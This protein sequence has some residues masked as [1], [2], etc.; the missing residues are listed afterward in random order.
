MERYSTNIWISGGL[1][2]RVKKLGLAS[3]TGFNNIS[4]E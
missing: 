2:L 1:F 4:G 3:I